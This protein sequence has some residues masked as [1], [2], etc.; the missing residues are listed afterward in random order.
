MKPWE[1]ALREQITQWIRDAAFTH[2]AHGDY[3]LWTWHMRAQEGW[4]E[5]ECNEFLKKFQHRI[6]NSI[7]HLEAWL[8]PTYMQPMG[9]EPIAKNMK[10]TLT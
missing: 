10:S 2:V 9:P 3:E 7:I 1:T 4:S 5:E 8:N 6:R